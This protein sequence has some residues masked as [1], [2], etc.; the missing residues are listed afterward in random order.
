MGMT[1]NPPSKEEVWHA[2]GPLEELPE[3]LRRALLPDGDF[4]PISVP[5]PDDWLAV[6]DEPGQTFL[7][8]VKSQP[9]RPDAVR[10]TIYLQPLDDFQKSA[11][12]PIEKLV[13]FAKAFFAMNVEVLPLLATSSRRITRRINPYTH[14][15]QLLT[16]DILRLL[17]E[18]LPENAFCVVAI[19]MRD[20]Y[21]GPSWN[22]VFGE[23]SLRYRVG[24]YS[25]AR[26]DPRFYGIGSSERDYLILWRSC[27]VLAHET[28]HMFGMQHCIY[29]KCLMNGSNH[30]EESDRRPLHL[31][32]VDLR[33]LHYSI[34]FDINQRYRNLLEFFKT[35]HFDDEVQWFERRLSHTAK[36]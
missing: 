2:V 19:T 22:F 29:F 30:L 26:Y 10:N 1:F 15:E 24:V 31:C 35:V 16:R 11:A 17:L 9:N 33:K 14:Q 12:P 36:S 21:P 20:L 13:Q 32:P 4:E 25:F 34:G 23:A 6:H 7:D 3:D 28:N 18:N 27:K 8:F 5:R